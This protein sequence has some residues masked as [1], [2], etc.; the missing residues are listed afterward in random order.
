[1]EILRG[2]G[3][4]LKAKFLEALANCMKI[5]WNFPEEVG[6]GV[7]NRKPSME[8]YGYFLRLSHLKAKIEIKTK[9]ESLTVND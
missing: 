2:E 6:G 5:N 8:V 9:C 3:G 1:M 4:V 7:Q